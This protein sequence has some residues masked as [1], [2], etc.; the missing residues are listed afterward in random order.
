LKRYYIGKFLG[1]RRI[2]QLVLEVDNEDY[3]AMLIKLFRNEKKHVFMIETLL[4]N[5]GLPLPRAG[6]RR[7]RYWRPVLK[8]LTTPEEHLAIAYHITVEMHKRTEALVNSRFGGADIKSVFKRIQR[9]EETAISVFR[10]CTT[11]EAL[12]KT[13]EIHKRG[14]DKLYGN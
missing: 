11:S 14:L 12:I 10:L 6:W 4:N 8:Q 2:E 1:A 13:T 9:D 7:T 5:R 3:Q